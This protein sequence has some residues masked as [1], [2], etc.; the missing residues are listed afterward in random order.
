[1]NG[2]VYS[3]V[4]LSSAARE[5]EYVLEVGRQQDEL[6]GGYSAWRPDVHAAIQAFLKEPSPQNADALL[7]LVPMF[8]P[9][10]QLQP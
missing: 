7:T 6:N 8:S 2:G 5:I 10:F 3:P 9:F 4:L 1:M